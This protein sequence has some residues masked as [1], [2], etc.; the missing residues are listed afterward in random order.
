MAVKTKAELRDYADAYRNT[1]GVQALT[2]ATENIMWN[3]MID[4]L[5]TQADLDELETAVNGSPTTVSTATYNTTSADSIL[6]VTRTATGTCTIDI[7]SLLISDDTFRLVIKDTG[8]ASRYNITITTEGS[9]TIDGETTW[10][11]NGDYDWI[12]VYSDGS[13]L[14]IKG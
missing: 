13:D 2:G 3:D 7:G 14:F 11:I 12:E 6:H 4:S 10:I 8:N 1:N 9:E 5:A